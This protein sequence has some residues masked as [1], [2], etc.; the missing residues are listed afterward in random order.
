MFA[1][2]HSLAFISIKN[3][4]TVSYVIACQ[5][6]H[7]WLHATIFPKTFNEDSLVGQ[8]HWFII[9]FAYIVFGFIVGNL[10]PFF[11]D[12]QALIGSLFGAPTIFGWPPLF[13]I[14][15][16]RSKNPESSWKETFQQ[17][18]I[19]HT[20]LCLL[21]LFVCTPLF[22]ILG[23][24]GAIQSIIEDSKSAMIKPFQCV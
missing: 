18:G 20:V 5:P 22:C 24:T 19:I 15:M 17:M 6:L 14:M 16:C 9:T 21:F 13:F 3:A 2:F 7:M 12:V 10:I 11:A 8:I 1:Y 4:V 23:T